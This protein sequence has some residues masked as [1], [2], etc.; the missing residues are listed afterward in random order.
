M[1]RVNVAI[2]FDADE[3]KLAE[4]MDRVAEAVSDVAGEEPMMGLQVDGEHRDPDEP[5]SSLFG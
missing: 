1:A 4:I 3:D 5:A 2:E